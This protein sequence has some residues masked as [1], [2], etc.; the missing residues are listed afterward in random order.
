MNYVVLLAGGVGTRMNASVAKQ[1][2][3]MGGHQ[4]IEYTLRVF[5][6]AADV[7]EIIVV[8]NADFIDA[9]EALKDR[10]HKLKHVVGG[11]PSRSLSVY[12]AVS[13]LQT[14]CKGDDRIMISD[15]VRPCITGREIRE[16]FSK[17]EQFPAVTTGVEVYETILQTAD[18]NLTGI[19]Q[20]DGVIRQTSPEAYLFSV[21]KELYIDTDLETVRQYRNIGID[22]LF[23]KG[24]QIGIV[25]STPLNFKITTQ[26]DLYYFDS[27]LKR[28][29]EKLMFSEY[30]AE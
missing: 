12:H 6:K 2:I 8:S 16:C 4:I 22:Q 21:L 5:D 1:H 19:I 26:E 18:Q 11:G 25:K 23:A 3:H 24:V 28:G 10:F 9:I 20:R 27:I 13:F 7:D 14:I 29:F 17:L 30:D 15:A